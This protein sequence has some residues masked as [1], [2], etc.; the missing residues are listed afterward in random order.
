MSIFQIWYTAMEY[1]SSDFP[2]IPEIE[3]YIEIEKK[4][5]SCQI[6]KKTA[7]DDLTS[8]IR[9]QA[10]YLSGHYHWL[11]FTV[12]KAPILYVSMAW[13]LQSDVPTPLTNYLERLV[14]AGIYQKLN[15]YFTSNIP[16][17]IERE[18]YT[19]NV[20]QQYG[21]RL[22]VKPIT[23]RDSIQTI[24]IIYLAGILLCFGIEIQ[25]ST[26]FYRREIW[27]CIR[28]LGVKICALFRNCCS[29]MVKKWRERK[30]SKIFLSCFN[31]GN[32]NYVL[33]KGRAT[34][35]KYKKTSPTSPN[36]K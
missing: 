9:K 11:T 22:R 4:I 23:L 10:N 7:F 26:V 18:E 24:F 16:N 31:R 6:G 3:Q 36:R 19:K 5:V 14:E 35:K 20:T 8:T 27:R 29:A 15:D 21:D 25:S 34:C 13:I 12:G 33:R 2:D 30:G 1:Q 32:S 17:K 28:Y